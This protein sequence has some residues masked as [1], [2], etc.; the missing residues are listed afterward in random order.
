M[1]HLTGGSIALF[2]FQILTTV[3]GW[4][5]LVIGP[6]YKFDGPDFLLE[7]RNKV[8]NTPI[9]EWNKLKVPEMY[10]PTFFLPLA[11]VFPLFGMF[12]VRNIFKKNLSS[13]GK[14][15]LIVVGVALYLINV[16]TIH[17]GIRN[18][19][20]NNK[21]FTPNGWYIC[22]GLIWL[23]LIL[24]CVNALAIYFYEIKSKHK[25]D[26]LS[27]SGGDSSMSDSS[28]IGSGSTQ[29]SSSKSK[30]RS[31]SQSGSTNNGKYES[32]KIR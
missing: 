26:E 9:T 1:Y 27:P 21:N 3:I 19:S 20:I 18:I 10:V 6:Y 24:L 14:I 2:F 7:G 13:M 11:V 29:K 4:F 17:Y 22:V 8:S 30:K 25:E 31:N 28:F 32:A 16:I 12:L 5:F 23:S 15:V